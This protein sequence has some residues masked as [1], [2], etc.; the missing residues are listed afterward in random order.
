MNRLRR[1]AQAVLVE[2]PLRELLPEIDRRKGAVRAEGEQAGRGAVDCSIWQGV[3]RTP[4]GALLSRNCSMAKLLHGDGGRELKRARAR[5]RAAA[6]LDDPPPQPILRAASAQRLRGHSWDG[7]RSTSGAQRTRPR[8]PTVPRYSCNIRSRQCAR[9]GGRKTG[10]TIAQTEST[11]VEDELAEKSTS[12]RTE[13]CLRR[14][15]RF[16]VRGE[17]RAG[18]AAGA[19]TENARSFDSCAACQCRLSRHRTV[20]GGCSRSQQDGV[21]R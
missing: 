8:R 1:V 5:E 2:L 16:R 21:R 15:R 6:T 4:A 12:L 3:P 19:A 11:H 7:S 18:A 13:I 9:S 17:T 14:P 10:L 20:R